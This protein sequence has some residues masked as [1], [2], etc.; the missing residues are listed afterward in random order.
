MHRTSTITAIAAA[1]LFFCSAAMALDIDFKYSDEPISPDA[2]LLQQTPSPVPDALHKIYAASY[3]LTSARAP[4]FD[5]EHHFIVV[6]DK[7][8][9]GGICRGMKLLLVEESG[10]RPKVAQRIKLGD[11]AF[12]ELVLLPS[13]HEFIMLRLMRQGGVSEAYVFASAGRG[14]L[15]ESFRIT[16]GAFDRLK[17]DTKATLAAGGLVEVVGRRPICDH[18]VDLSPALE[19]LID[20]GV[21]QADGR[22]VPALVNLKKARAGWEGE[23]L[24]LR[25]GKV[26][27]DIGFSMATVS[28]TTILNS[29]VSLAQDGSG[30][31]QPA[32]LSVE[33]FMAYASN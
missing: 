9:E 22:P 20:D 32:H 28:G 26:N 17:L 4:F 11:G 23:A 15:T 5:G 13:G 3:V 6:C 27:I 30:K 19:A 7:V 14:K 25:D 2:V 18:D 12:P 10:E 8:T 16:R 1:A 29:M 33:P 24:V 31:W 21:Y